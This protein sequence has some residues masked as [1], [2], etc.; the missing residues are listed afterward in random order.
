M[1]MD[2]DG[3]RAALARRT[4]QGLLSQALS[5]A[6]NFALVVVIART[7]TP[8]VFGA[9]AVAYAATQ[10]LVLM[11]RSAIGDTLAVTDTSERRP[12]VGAAVVLALAASAIVTGVG[13]LWPQP[14]LGRW[15][16]IFAASL[17]VLAW[18]EVQR[19]AAFALQRPAVA[20]ASDGIWVAVQVT[21]WVVAFTADAATPVVLLTVWVAGGVAGGVVVS[22]WLGVPTVR[23]A[24]GWL[25]RHRRL[26]GG[27]AAEML[28]PIAAMQAAMYAVA[29]VAGLAAAGGLQGAQSLL[30]PVRTMQA[31][32][33]AVALPEASSRAHTGR[34]WAYSL[35]LSIGLA[36]ASAVVAG[37]LALLPEPVGRQ[38]LGDTWPIAATVVIPV[39]AT[40][41]LSGAAVGP[42]LGFRVMHA[43][44]SLL[45]FRLE[46]A[47]LLMAFGVGGAVVAGLQGAA[48]GLAV[49]HLVLLPVA[50]TRFRRIE[51]AARGGS[52]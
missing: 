47:A 21:G 19:G 43:T 11:A 31:G 40:L 37:V 33:A 39:G 13:L 10:L 2:P 50:W 1:G 14:L 12:A 34:L 36:A 7:A 30:G 44:G 4:F 25:S 18:N 15:L 20:A 16:A 9:F 22:R 49:A 5:S 45:A 24:F 28:M 29:I 46:Q 41:V 3:Q 6:S 48:Y 42:V 32:V 23:G 38:L 8:E 35:W 26:A 17:P 52:G 27:F 51:R